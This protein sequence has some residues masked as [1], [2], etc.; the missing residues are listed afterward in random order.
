[1]KGLFSICLAVFLT[2]CATY[3]PTSLRIKLPNGGNGFSIFCEG[4]NFF[5]ET[6]EVVEG[7]WG[8]CYYEAGKACPYGYSIIERRT[9]ELP[10]NTRFY[11]PRFMVIKCKKSGKS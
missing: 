10:E 9:K 7:G 4:K 3:L 2:G 11:E 5:T 6:G 1:M 8:I